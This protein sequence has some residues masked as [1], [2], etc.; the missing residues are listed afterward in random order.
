MNKRNRNRF[1]FLLIVG[2]LTFGAVMLVRGNSDNTPIAFLFLGAVGLLW[3][4]IE[5]INKSN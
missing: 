4:I 3:K 1:E 2:L 5:Q